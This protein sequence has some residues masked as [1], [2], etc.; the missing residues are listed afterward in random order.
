VQM[1]RA[2]IRPALEGFKRMGDLRA[3]PRSLA[4]VVSIAEEGGSDGETEGM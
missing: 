1:S 2:N 3:G 4:R